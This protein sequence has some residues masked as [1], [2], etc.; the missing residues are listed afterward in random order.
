MLQH[1]FS[2]NDVV[3]HDL[4]FARVVHANVE[5]LFYLQLNWNIR[6]TNKIQQPK[7]IY[8]KTINEMKLNA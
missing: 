1:V 3:Q 6:M 4:K 7:H 8:R 5:Y 2:S